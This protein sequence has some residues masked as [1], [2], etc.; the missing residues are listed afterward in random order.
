MQFAQTSP[1]KRMTRA[2]AKAAEEGKKPTKITTPA[3][4]AA[5][6]ASKKTQQ[7]ATDPS[8]GGLEENRNTKTGASK[9]TKPQARGKA[10]SK[11]LAT[12]RAKPEERSEEP[13][14]N[15]CSVQSDGQNIR[16]RRSAAISAAT[17]LNEAAPAEALT[18][19]TRARAET[20]RA[21]AATK[22]TSSKKKVTFE[23]G[24]Q[25]DKENIV[26]DRPTTRRGNTGRKTAAANQ[27]ATGS[28]AAKKPPARSG[29]TKRSKAAENDESNKRPRPEP[30]SPKK[31][32][33]VA[34]GN[35]DV[36]EDV[37]TSPEKFGFG[38]PLKSVLK[39][40][41]R[42]TAFNET[43][44]RSEDFSNSIDELSLPDDGPQSPTKAGPS[45]IMGSPARRPPHSPFKDSMKAMPLKGS[46]Y[47]STKAESSHAS[48]AIDTLNSR[49]PKKI[50]LGAS[51]HHPVLEAPSQ[52]LIAGSIA[53]SPPR[54][55]SSPINPFGSSKLRNTPAMP[56]RNSHLQ[57]PARRP[58]PSVKASMIGSSRT[59]A[60]GQAAK[61]LSMSSISRSPQKFNLMQPKNLTSSLKAIRSPDA[62]AKVHKMT[63]EEQAEAFVDELAD[64]PSP[65]SPAKQPKQSPSKSFNE[66]PGQAD[67]TSLCEVER[68]EESSE[69]P[70]E[71]ADNAGDSAIPPGARGGEMWPK[72]QT[73]T[74]GVLS[75]FLEDPFI[76]R[77]EGTERS[78]ADESEDELQ[79]GDPNFNATPG[80]RRRDPFLSPE[81]PITPKEAEALEGSASKSSKINMTAL[82][83]RF[84]AWTGASP[85]QIIIEQRKIHG[86][87][88]SPIK[89]PIAS[90]DESGTAD[91][92]TPAQ[93][94]NTFEEAMDI[95]EDEDHPMPD[96]NDPL[97]GIESFRQSIVSDGSQDYGDENSMPIDPALFESTEEREQ[98][99]TPAHL[100]AAQR[101]VLYTTSKVPLK[102][103]AESDESPLDRSKPKRSKS[104]SMALTP[105]SNLELQAFRQIHPHGSEQAK[106]SEVQG[107]WR[108]SALPNKLYLQPQ[109]KKGSTPRNADSW[110]DAGTPGR[111]PRPGLNARLLRGAVVFVDVHTSEGADASSIFVDLLTQM[112]ARCVKHWNWNSRDSVAGNHSPGGADGGGDSRIG[113]THVVFKDG[114][115]RTM[116][117]VREARDVVTCVGVGWVLE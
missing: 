26:E 48:N 39:S 9:P 25:E 59:P 50:D 35:Q 114:G 66:L 61:D 75:P 23:D 34:K 92:A 86:S 19:R 55:P 20:S 54:R 47:S 109:P 102:P 5:S 18:T 115:K 67:S 85:D 17:S 62:R 96:Q 116:E 93:A 77:Q 69:Y 41:Q 107:S 4:R 6:A 46:D 33:Q 72:T 52:D 56:E 106:F 110:S 64:A 113:I 74:P 58:P 76:S 87:V 43:T 83:D 60:T 98:T 42:S 27:S 12:S 94:G 32:V 2:R 40:P 111:T 16:G 105:E 89:L 51:R 29:P 13:E 44:H 30:L 10:R 21:T 7:V 82:A 11:T 68:P 65:Y 36:S 63:P 8:Q 95:R 49:S 80:E 15:T 90:T 81:V 79:S 14:S 38:S 78:I 1:P 112:G 3:A 73:M 101:P 99:C 45:T 104:M 84:G 31:E 53:Q 91:S 100:I 22:S 37:L 70:P 103:A 117:K 71:S 28:R 57:S 24:L 97:A 108:S 88:F